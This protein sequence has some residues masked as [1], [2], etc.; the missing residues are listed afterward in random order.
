MTPE[1]AEEGQS[2]PFTVLKAKQG[3]FQGH[4]GR[5]IRKYFREYCDHAGIHGLRY[6]A[7]TKRA[8]TER[9][10][11]GILIIISIS[12]CGYMISRIYNKYEKSPV[13]VSFATKESP[14]FSI[15]FPAV[16]ICP[17]SKSNRTKLNYTMVIKKKISK[18][19]LPPEIELRAQYMSLVCENGRE[20]FP[21][22]DTFTDDFFVKLDEVPDNLPLRIPVTTNIPCIF[23][24]KVMPCEKLFKPIITDEGICYTFNMLDR[25]EIF[26]DNVVHYTNYHKNDEV[27]KWNID[28]GYLDA[29]VTTFPRRALFSGADNALE[30][31]LPQT[32]ENIDYLC[33]RDVQGYSFTL[34]TPHTIPNP[35][36]QFYII[37][38][39]TS[40]VAVVQPRMMT[41][42]QGVKDYDPFDRKCYLARERPL[43]FFKIY[44]PENCRLECLAN[45]TLK[46]CGCVNFF[47]PRD[48]ETSICSNNKYNCMKKSERR[49]MKLELSNIMNMTLKKGHDIYCNCMP[50]CTDLSYDTEQSHTVWDW[51]EQLRVFQAGMPKKM[52]KYMK[53]SKLSVFFKLEHF[54]TTERNELYGPT[55]FLANFGGLLGLFTGFSLLSLVEIIYFLTLRIFCN[56]KKYKEWSGLAE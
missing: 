44:S 19:I 5:R 27:S 35:K 6:I 22:N 30:I 10:I 7:E 34:H 21:N 37:P 2:Y 51:D 39:D 14:I 29:N 26:N 12:A 13:I 24:K 16:T 25:N 9:F 43:K 32:A 42:S 1:S 20:H 54:W 41:T 3:I 52:R 50:L 46:S 36:K 15:P 55:D 53:M 56:I 17:I 33:V 48:N 4:R 38:F 47:M 18:E 11:W 28:D 49:M 31:M 40:V 23:M 45:H 8:P